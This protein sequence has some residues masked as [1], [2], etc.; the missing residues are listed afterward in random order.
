MHA[1]CCS[2]PGRCSCG[3]LP[4]LTCLPNVMFVCCMYGQQGIIYLDCPLGINKVYLTL[5]V[6]QVLT[7]SRLRLFC[8][9]HH[10]VYT[11]CADGYIMF[12]LRSSRNSSFFCQYFQATG[13]RPIQSNCLC[14]MFGCCWTFKCRLCRACSIPNMSVSCVI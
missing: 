7:L 5:T 4:S 1:H 6:G 8:L 10:I 3:Q 11:G 2:V 9:M 13:L 12:S 14:V